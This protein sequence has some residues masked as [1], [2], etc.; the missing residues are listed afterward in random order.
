MLT[1]WQRWFPNCAPIAHR[2]RIAFADRWVRFH[3]L[4]ES[5]R[6]PEDEPEYVTIL[7]RHNRIL[8]ELTRPGQRVVLLSTGYSESPEPIRSEPQWQVLDPEA[9]PWHSVVM[10]EGDANFAKPSYWHVFASEREWW[11]GTFDPLV[12]MVADSVL[13]N[14]MVVSSDCRWLL[15]PYDGGMDVI[16]ESPAVRDRLKANHTEWLSAR[17]DGL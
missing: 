13:A 12:R 11:P 15:H 3:S 5:K 10:D 6:Y 14:V 9:V 16:A 8:G 2:L 1:G 17:A 4:P 7:E